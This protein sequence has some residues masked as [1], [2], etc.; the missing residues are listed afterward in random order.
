MITFTIW[1]LRIT[2]EWDAADTP[3]ETPKAKP[4]IHVPRQDVHVPDA[5]KRKGRN[6]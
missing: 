1:K 3:A 4:R 5:Q 6:K 2:I